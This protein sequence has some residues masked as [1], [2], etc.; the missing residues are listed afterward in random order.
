VDDIGSHVHVVAVASLDDF[1]IVVAV[2][3]VVVVAAVADDADDCYVVADLMIFA[4]VF[5]VSDH[6]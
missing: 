1:A 4:A 2:V 5:V 3:V 6:Y